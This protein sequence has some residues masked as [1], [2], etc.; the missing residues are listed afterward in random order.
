MRLSPF[1]SAQP[2]GTPHFRWSR[3]GPDIEADAEIT[4]DPTDLQIDTFRASSAG[5]QHMQKNWKRRF[6]HAH[7]LRSRRPVR[8]SACRPRTGRGASNSAAR[9]IQIQ[10]EEHREQLAAPGRARRCRVG[11]PDS[12]LC[13]SSLPDG[14]DHRTDYET[15]NVQAVLDGDLDALMEA[16]LREQVGDG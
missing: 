12:V 3:C 11:K 15:G 13:P 6:D 1:D 14:Q 2:G 10:E 7:T 9:L 8:T 5:G 4:I 16:F